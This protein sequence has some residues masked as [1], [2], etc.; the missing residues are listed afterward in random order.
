MINEIFN[1]L[2]IL[3]TETDKVHE[4]NKQISELDGGD[5]A[6]Q[7]SLISSNL[8]TAIVKVID[9]YLEQLTGNW[10]LASYYLYECGKKGKVFLE[11]GVEYPITSVQELRNYVERSL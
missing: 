3:D 7:I 9:K 4:I 2:S 1:I 11:N 6:P 8:E 10:G 5:F